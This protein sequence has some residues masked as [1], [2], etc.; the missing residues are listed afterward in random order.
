MKSI[1]A[2]LFGTVVAA[3]FGLFAGTNEASAATTYTVNQGDTLSTISTNF[4]GSNSAIDAIAQA[5]GITDVNMIYVGQQLTIP[6]DGEATTETAAV[7]AA[8]VQETTTPTAPAS[9]SDA[10]AKEWIA[11][12]ESS[13][14]YTATNGQYYGRYQLTSSYLNGD[15]SPENQEAVADAYVAGRY[16]SWSAAKD[17]WLANGWY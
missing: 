17:F 11:M 4:F 1:K 6:T 12:K 3:G 13:G 8:P 14:S 7:E 16:G 15:F 5:S 9:S 2:L 10:E